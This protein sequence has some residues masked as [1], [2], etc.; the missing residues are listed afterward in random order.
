MRK[1]HVH[2][3][4]TEDVPPGRHELRFEF[5][6]T[7]PPVIPEGKGAPGIGQL[8]FDGRL[9]GQAEVPVTTPLV[10]GL[11]SALVCGA[12]PGS[13]V[14]SHYEPPFEFTGIL[15]SVT[16]D[17]SGDLIEDDEATMRRLMA[18]Q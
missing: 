7:G 12:G 2:G 10:L 3:V 17:V 11:T 15:H 5:E 4:S 13:P 8:Y 1:G 6:V 16:I 14:C 18:Q 9:V